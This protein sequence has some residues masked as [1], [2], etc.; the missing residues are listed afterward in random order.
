MT[1]WKLFPYLSIDHKAAQADLNDM[2]AKGWRLKNIYGGLLARFQRAEDGDFTYFVDL[3]DPQL[4]EDPDYLALCADAGWDEVCAPRY[5]RIYESRPSL[6]PAPIQTDGGVE[7]ERFLR[8]C[9]RRMLITLGLMALLIAIYGLFF[10]LTSRKGL[11]LILVHSFIGNFLY[12]SAIPLFLGVLAYFL[13]LLLR[14]RAWNALRASG[15][16]I[17]IPRFARL[18][19][20]LTMLGT[21]YLALTYAVMALDFGTNPD[22]NMAGFFVGFLLAIP[23]LIWLKAKRPQRRVNPLGANPVIYMV[24][25]AFLLRLFLPAGAV[26][27]FSLRVDPLPEPLTAQMTSGNQKS[28]WLSANERWQ[29]TLTL[30]KDYSFVARRHTLRTDKLADMVYQSYLEYYLEP[31]P[32]LENTWWTPD[33]KPR[34]ST[35]EVVLLRDDT[36]WYF[37]F[38]G[39]HLPP[40][41]PALLNEIITQQEAAP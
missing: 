4:K 35:S 15:A 14:I 11:V 41:V 33:G 37:M 7:Y 39:S 29:S 34:W 24:L 40:E 32:G 28:Y 2:A 26:V 12:L 25:F 10:V 22:M 3:A 13:C 19:G 8:I 9:F 36:V 31:F 16:P 6:D 20:T 21:L 30:E 23:M 17:P 5:M 27:P 1:R 38:Y 18:R